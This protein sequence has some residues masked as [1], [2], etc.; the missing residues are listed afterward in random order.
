MYFSLSRNILCNLL[1]TSDIGGSSVELESIEN[2]LQ[3]VVEKMRLGATSASTSQVSL[4]P[5]PGFTVAMKDGQLPKWKEIASHFRSCL[6]QQRSDA[7]D[8]LKDLMQRCKT[9]INTILILDDYVMIDDRIIDFIQASLPFLN[10]SK[11]LVNEDQLLNHY[12]DLLQSLT[13][14]VNDLQQ[15]LPMGMNI[16]WA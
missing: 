10:S 2:E 8:K 3:Q 9:L 11:A 12:S 6:D 7:K 13:I 5:P 16:C 1:R 15:R 4:T 14:I